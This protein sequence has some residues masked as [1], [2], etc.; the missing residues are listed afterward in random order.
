MKKFVVLAVCLVVALFFC[1]FMA[2]GPIVNAEGEVT[3]TLTTAEEPTVTT[4]ATVVEP[5]IGIEITDD[6]VII[7]GLPDGAPDIVLSKDE[8]TQ[9]LAA[10]I[11]ENFGP[12][13]TGI[14]ISAGVI[15]AIVITLICIALN[16]MVKHVKNQRES[17]VVAKSKVS[18]DETS[19][20][21]LRENTTRTLRAEKRAMKAEAYG[22]IAA[23]GILT[24][25]S[26]SSNEQNAVAASSFQKELDFVNKIDDEVPESEM[27]TAMAKIVKDATEQ[28]KN[29]A[30]NAGAG[31]LKAKK[32][33][34]IAAIQASD[35]K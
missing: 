16:Y 5:G 32:S 12:A 9:F 24:F 22:A 6:S 26:N 17:L 14:G 19:T 28:V 29:I 31:I 34:L 13:L 21:V 30:A 4:E 8:A 23:K 20:T 1:L 33:A 11:E 15:A 35:G 7:S 10:I 25:L 27:K 18:S 2:S 3:T